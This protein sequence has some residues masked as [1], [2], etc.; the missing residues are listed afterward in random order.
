VTPASD[1]TTVP[2]HTKAPKGTQAVIRA[3]RLLK[4]VARS[5]NGATLTELS[6]FLS[7]SPPTTHRI[8]AALESEG[9]LTQDAGS[10]LYTLGA[11]AL[12][13]GAHALHKSDLRALAR[14]MLHRLAK[15][16]GETASLEIPVEGEMLIL[17][18]VAGSQII[19]ARIEVGTRWPLY[20]T[21]TGKALLASLS[22]E[23]LELKLSKPRQRFT[24][25]TLVNTDALRAD[26]ENARSLG[27]ASA[28]GELEAGYAAV[29]AI[30][31]DTKSQPVGALSLGGPIERFSASRRSELGRMIVSTA[32]ELSNLL[33]SR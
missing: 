30:I 27:Y 1:H 28:E 7:L 25:A 22:E 6:T 33:S 12:T 19:G 18:E 2:D 31:C 23:E 17:D 8:L 5:E 29:G 32:A 13:I 11:S 26:L 16:G 21:S 9:L 10:K 14:P 24:A 20:A 15:E 4:A 3:V